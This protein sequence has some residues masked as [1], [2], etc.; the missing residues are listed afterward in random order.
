MARHIGVIETLTQLF[1]SGIETATPAPSQKLRLSGKGLRISLAVA[2]FEVELGR[3]C[4]QIYP[5]VPVTGSSTADAPP[6][7]LL[8]DPERYFNG[9]THFLRV[10][11][12]E[13]LAIS[14]H[15]ETQKHVFGHPRDAF[16]RHLEIV[17]QGDG[18]IFKDTIS[19]LGSY[20]SLLANDRD[21]VR[22]VNRRKE[23]LRHV[24]EIFGGPLELLPPADALGTLRQ[25]NA[26]LREGRLRR[27]DAQGNA[28]GL[29]ELPPQLTPILVGDLHAQ[30]DNLLT[31]LSQNAFMQ[32]LEQGTAAL[33]FLG[34]AVHP[35]PPNDLEF[36]DSSA[37][38]MDLI[39]KLMLR[40]P[41]QVFFIL[42]NHESFSPEVMKGGVPQSLLWG[43]RIVEM[44]GK[45]YK[46]E[47][48]IFYQQC[49][50]V[51]IGEGF[52]ACHAGPASSKISLKTLVN[53]REF[54]NLVHDLT[55]SRVKTPGFPVGYTRGAVKRFRKSLGLDKK[56]PFIVAHYPLDRDGTLWLN[57]GGIEQHH[58]VYSARPDSVAV[59]TR[60]D[61]EMV[62]QVYP[63]EP[64]L[65]WVNAPADAGVQV[66]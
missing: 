29:L 15:D 41:S 63:T 57:V 43:Q 20:V 55:W 35:E 58:I 22:V 65:E 25:V 12:G 21:A 32:A 4:L 27:Q 6:D 36:M 51:V 37:L 17:H 26:L 9:I 16:R 14:H 13:K 44:R 47:M 60:V 54:P 53:I 42:G 33:I 66:I 23:A 61:G 11:A 39:F 45:A 64:L 10:R 2:P 40:F 5:D 18:L 48:A 31:I 8:F 28:G 38:M 62:P 56:H 34:D 19:E 30:V 3:Q 1:S 46:Q 49:P 59:F 50:L 7:I 24:R 52:F